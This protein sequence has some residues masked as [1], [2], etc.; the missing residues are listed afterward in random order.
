M[1]NGNESAPVSGQLAVPEGELP[2]G[3]GTQCWQILGALRFY[4]ASIVVCGHLVRAVPDEGIINKALLWFGRMDPVAAVIGFLVISGFSIAHSVSTKPAGYYRRRVIRIYPLYLVGVLAAV[5]LHLLLGPHI[6]MFRG[7]LGQPGAAQLAGNLVFLQ[8]FLVQPIR[9]NGPRWTLAVE[10]FCYLFAPLLLSLKARNLFA[11]MCV[12][13]LAYLV[14]PKLHLDFYSALRWGLPV[15]FLGWAWLAGFALYRQRA[16]VSFALL[17]I[18]LGTFALCA[19]Q[20]GL[21]RFAPFTFVLSVAVLTQSPRIRLPDVIAKVLGYAGE[22]S[23]PLYIIHFPALVFGS[24]VLGLSNGLALVALAVLG[25][26][27]TYHLVDAPIRLRSRRR[28]HAS[29]SILEAPG[30]SM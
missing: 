12:S 10:V 23:Y 18:F 11:L 17:I 1:R 25:A 16:E 21:T 6:V 14:F 19:N 8:T 3:A 13:L 5:G 22:L 26:A 4:L 2:F 20:I 29:S 28:A 27:L 30:T 15:L 7:E 24:V 9:A